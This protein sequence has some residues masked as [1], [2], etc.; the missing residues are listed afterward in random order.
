MSWLSTPP[1]LVIGFA[2][3]LLDPAFATVCLVKALDAG[4][5]EYLD[6]TSKSL[7]DVRT[8]EGRGLRMWLLDERD[9]KHYPEAYL[10]CFPFL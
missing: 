8:P 1:L 3:P 6:R 5:A 2:E 9:L 4:N 7:L 10:G